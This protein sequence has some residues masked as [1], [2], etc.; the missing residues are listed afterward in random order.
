MFSLQRIFGRGDRFFE[1][2]EASA[3][4]ARR[5]AQAV[6]KLIEAPDNDHTL[7]PFIQ[8]R[9][10]EKRIREDISRMVCNTFITPFEREDI[11]TLSI[12]LSRISKVL[13]KF[14]ERLLLLRPHFKTELFTKQSIL[15]QQAIDTLHE[16][17]RQ[18]RIRDSISFRLPTTACINTKV[19]PT[20]SCSRCCGSCTAA[21]TTPCR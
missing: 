15:L 6:G 12:A 20:S 9:K 3:D 14:A 17:V 18:L 2:L 4:E 11:D 10:E 8:F 5:A 7:D 19:M 13:K 21:S 1:L 16:M